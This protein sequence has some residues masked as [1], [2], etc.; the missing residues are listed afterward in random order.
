MNEKQSSA[1]RF[2]A[3]MHELG[4]NIEVVTLADST[5]TAKEAADTLGC[6]VAQIAKSIVFRDPNDDSPVLVVASGTNRVSVDKVQ[7][8]SGRKLEQ[9]SGGFVKKRLGFAIGGVP[10]AGHTDAVMTFLD[11]DLQRYDELWAAAGNPF[12]VFQ[13]TPE[14]LPSLTNANW[15]DVAE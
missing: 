3:R 9:A 15:A 6:S 2:L 7:G 4:H 11:T 1:D 14:M 10:P 12:A 13:L 8:L 5:R